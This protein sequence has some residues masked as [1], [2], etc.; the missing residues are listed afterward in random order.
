MAHPAISVL[1]S[2]FTKLFTQMQTPFHS[3]KDSSLLGEKGEENRKHLISKVLED[4]AME[5][6]LEKTWLGFILETL[7]S[8]S[9]FILKRVPEFEIESIT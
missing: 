6:K 9:S 4:L 2:L 1:S 7:G 8:S 3:D 5:T